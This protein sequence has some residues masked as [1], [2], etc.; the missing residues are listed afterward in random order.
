L[1]ISLILR[2]LIHANTALPETPNARATFVGPPA[3][4]TA[5]FT[6]FVNESNV[7]I[8]TFLVVIILCTADESIINCLSYFNLFQIVIYLE[9]LW[10]MGFVMTGFV[11]E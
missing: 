1:C 10:S 11:V 8:V 5:A 4:F 7:I 3:R 6:L 9:A 2:F